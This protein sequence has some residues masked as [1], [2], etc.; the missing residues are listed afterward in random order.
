MKVMKVH[1]TLV[2]FHERVLTSY[3]ELSK[4]SA[5]P[6]PD[7]TKKLL[8]GAWLLASLVRNR[9]QRWIIRKN[10][11]LREQGVPENHLF[12]LHDLGALWTGSA[13]D[14]LLPLPAQFVLLQ[15]RLNSVRHDD[16]SLSSPSALPLA[17]EV[18][19]HRQ[20]AADT[21]SEGRHPDDYSSHLISPAS[22]SQFQPSSLLSPES[23]NRNCRRSL[24]KKRSSKREE[25]LRDTDEVEEEVLSPPHTSDLELAS[26]AAVVADPR[27]ASH[28]GAYASAAAA[29]TESLKTH[30]L[31]TRSLE[32]RGLTAQ[33]F[34]DE[35]LLH[36]VRREQLKLGGGNGAQPP[37][38]VL[39]FDDR[40]L[41]RED[42]AY[43]IPNCVSSLPTLWNNN[44]GASLAPDDTSFSSLTDE[45]RR[46]R[47]D[48]SS[49]MMMPTTGRDRRKAARLLR[50]RQEREERSR[51]VHGSEREE[52]PYRGT[53][54]DDDVDLFSEHD[55]TMRD[56]FEQI[57][58]GSEGDGVELKKRTKRE[59]R[60]RM[61]D[62]LK[63]NDDSKHVSELSGET[64]FVKEY[65][66]HMPKLFFKKGKI[67]VVNWR[68]E[69][70]NH[71]KGEKRNG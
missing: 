23:S 11:A 8:R 51:N 19:R 67:R 58:N 25:N 1:P 45:E 7:N 6:H 70:K 13:V 21:N 59:S 48:K 18:S 34:S 61:N 22:S 30:P 27:A 31:F 36:N 35:S 26:L 37:L 62:H 71:N 55:E 38:E 20:L 5:E 53:S 65:E 60:G 10:E 43:H 47:Y 24:N 33:F 63:K 44:P 12:S 69:R 49:R 15:E 42:S 3:L 64:E 9:R 68:G 56:C 40:V 50:K 57:D 2:R 46:L 66:E 14:P 39:P 52:T 32:G 29:A 4:L 54:V 16:S 17:A 28:P 41:S